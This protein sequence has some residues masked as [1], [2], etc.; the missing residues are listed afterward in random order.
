MGIVGIDHWVMV[1]GDLDKTLDF[2]ARLGFQIAWE[3]RPGRPGPGMPTIRISPS[4]KINVHG[5]DFPS[6]PGYLGARTPAASAADFCLE[7]RGTVDEILALLE[8]NGI[9][10]EAGPGPRTCARGTSTSVYFRD[11]DGNLVEF[12]VYDRPA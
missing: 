3:P 12:T 9:A 5:P 1:A 7:W 2:Y 8:K 6:R 11:P 10:V 4:Q